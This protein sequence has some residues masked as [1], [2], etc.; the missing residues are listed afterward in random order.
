MVAAFES[1]VSSGTRV[2]LESA[3]RTPE[4][5]WYVAVGDLDVGPLDIHE[6]QTRFRFGELFID[7]LA[8]RPGM[9][10]WLPIADLPDLLFHLDAERRNQETNLTRTIEW[11]SAIAVSLA[12]LVAQELEAA[13]PAPV[14]ATPVAESYVGL[15]DLRNLGFAPQGGQAA[16]D[17]PWG[18]AVPAQTWVPPAQPWLNASRES[19]AHQRTL[20]LMAVAMGAL[21]VALAVALGLL[22]RPARIAVAAMPAPVPPT[23]PAPAR[24]PVLPLTPVMPAEA[25]APETPAEEQPALAAIPLPTRAKRE[26][27]RIAKSKPEKVRAVVPAR[28]TTDE[29]EANTEDSTLSQAQVIEAVKANASGLAPCVRA[30]R[31]NGELVPGKIRFVLSW[32]VA[33]NGQVRTP[34]LTGPNEVLNTTLPACFARQMSSWDFPK[35]GAPTT[36]RNFPLPVN[37]R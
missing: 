27:T 1:S 23:A 8:W 36:I 34:R 7:T 26:P 2:F 12:D 10:D 4:K 6:I 13:T 11:K 24:T 17:L 15:P 5:E 33:P 19:Q 32:V 21:I 9:R 14:V 28:D 31:S 3:P 18:P 22:L 30:A 35:A 25:A 29:E 20:T 37:V 16:W